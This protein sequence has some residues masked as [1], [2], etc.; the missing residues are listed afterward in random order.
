MRLALIVR[1]SHK[2]K[3]GGDVV[4][5]SAYAHWLSQHGHSVVVD[6]IGP[7]TRSCDLAF[8]F[9]LDL[10]SE[11]IRHGQDLAAHGCPYIAVPI[12][13]PWQWLGRFEEQGRSGAWRAANVVLRTPGMRDR[14]RDVGRS[15]TV[16]RA[17]WH[18]ASRKPLVDQAAEVLARAAGVVYIAEGER[19]HI[20]RDFGVAPDGTLVR[21]GVP[22]GPWSPGSARDIDIAVVG[23]IE[24]RKN[25]LHLARALA[26]T[27]MTVVFAGHIAG[28]NQRYAHRL[29]DVIDA[30]DNLS[31]VGQ[32]AADE[33][34]AVLRR[35]KVSASA[36]WVEVASLVDIEAYVAGCDVVASANGFS[37]E[38]GIEGLL[39]L[40]PQSSHVEVVEIC[41]LAL[42][43]WSEPSA[44]D[45]SNR[46]EKHS[47]QT[48]LAP[49]AAVA[50]TARS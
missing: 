12:H 35:T 9:N 11:W 16:S 23:R 22:D 7:E 15:R 34:Q 24:E 25:Q 17:Q 1:A 8:I 3:P 26:G 46:L 33:M 4:Q 39:E 18:L 20:E 43:G 41:S 10:M 44:S 32:L 29:L 13:H 50:T 36:S 6:T 30:A 21:N 27:S 37:R 28:A 14:A 5:A 40:D 38:Y 42:A 2:T 48:T 45:L 31:Y 19:T 47:W 49:L